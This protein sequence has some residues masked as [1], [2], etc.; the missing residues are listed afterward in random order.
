MIRTLKREGIRKQE[1]LHVAE[2][3]FH[4]HVPANKVGLRSAWIRRQSGKACWNAVLPPE[5]I[6]R[7]DFRF[8]SL[9]QMAKAHQNAL[10][11]S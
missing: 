8:E 9:A 4:D 11:E 2:S 10:R 6:P 1:I 7:Y 5:R 3:L